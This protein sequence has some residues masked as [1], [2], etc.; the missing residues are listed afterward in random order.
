MGLSGTPRSPMSSVMPPMLTGDDSVPI[1]L[2]DD[3][4]A[5]LDALEAS[6]ASS[7]CTFVLARTADEALL[8]LL[9]QDF[10]AI[11]LDVMMPGMSGFDLASMIKRRERT[12][13]VPILFLTARMLDQQD[14]LRGY[15][16]GA[17]DYLTKPIDP[18]ILRSKIA[19]FVDLFRKRR[20]LARM[21]MELQRQISERQKIADA[22]RRANDELEARVADRTAALAEANRRKDDFLSMLGHELRNP[23]SALRSAAE[24]LRLKASDIPELLPMQGVFQRQLQQMTRL[25][26]DLLD[27]SRIT[28]DKL[29][30]QR[31]RVSLSDIIDGAMDIVRALTET[32][33][34]Q[35]TVNLPSA[36]V[37]LDG[38]LARLTQVIGNVLD[39]AVR[40]S[41]T[42][43]RIAVSVEESGAH[44]V[45]KVKDNGAG[46]E[47]DLLPRIFDFFVQ[48]HRAAQSTSGLGV[49]LPLARR[50]VEMHGGTI[51]CFS[52]GPGHGTEVV[53]RLP[54][55]SAGDQTAGATNGTR[56]STLERRR[57]LIVEDNV[58]TASMMNLMLLEWGQETKVAHDGLAALD[59]AAEF[60]PDVVLLDIGLPRLHGYEVARRLRQQD[61]ARDT[62]VVAI[63]GWGLGADRQGEAAGIDHRLLKPVD[64]ETLRS[65]LG[66][67]QRSTRRVS[68]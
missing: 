68:P 26:N 2:V 45:L 34:Q 67:I 12:R 39:N 64:P 63:T 27:V 21:N 48:G 47:R 11:V 23:L 16:S 17:V 18:K 36:P 33:Q 14:E 1:L 43:S 65:L 59:V 31:D 3:Q 55:L 22:L 32:R 24:A 66:E 54:A 62:H 42:G 58:D 60:R 10:A 13:E 35:V 6:L 61:W 51:A 8:A 38:D 15:G 46:I 37:Y 29:V 5:N 41:P 56:A 53:V 20:A 57:I 19:V 40:Y 25:T 9:H 30:L 50:L 4:P 52:A 28:R 44:V 49:G 7:G